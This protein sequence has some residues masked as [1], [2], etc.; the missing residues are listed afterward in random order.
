M[1]CALWE[2][3]VCTIYPWFVEYK[4]PP[5]QP[6]ATLKVHIKSSDEEPLSPPKG[7]WISLDSLWRCDHERVTCIPRFFLPPP[8]LSITPPFLCWKLVFARCLLFWRV[9]VDY[10]HSIRTE[11]NKQLWDNWGGNEFLHRREEGAD[12]S[13]M[14][15]LGP[16]VR[17]LLRT[18]PA[19][20][21]LTGTPGSRAWCQF[22]QVCPRMPSCSAWQIL[23][24]GGRASV[25]VRKERESAGGYGPSAPQIN[26]PYTHTHN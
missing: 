4:E 18:A 20:S 6:K 2:E 16:H 17:P 7:I 8:F 22:R 13:C 15:A 11:L 19:P 23:L 3:R 21:R 26:F 25:C 14:P 1:P 12:V 10:T 9:A 5:G 24:S